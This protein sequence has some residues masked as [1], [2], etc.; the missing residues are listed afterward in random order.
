[1]AIFIALIAGSSHLKRILLMILIM[2]LFS[3]GKYQVISIPRRYAGNV[4]KKL[5]NLLME[6]GNSLDFSGKCMDCHKDIVVSCT[7]NP[8]TLEYAIENGALFW[9]KNSDLP[10]VKCP[11]CF[12]KNP[13]VQECDIYDRCVGYLRPIKNMSDAKQ[14]EVNARKR[15]RIESMPA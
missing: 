2:K 13:N 1:M 3:K 10:K 14:A 15:F 11:D 6:T 4:M 7:V 8:D 12:G 5:E 9:H